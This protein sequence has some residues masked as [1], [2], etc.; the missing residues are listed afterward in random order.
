[1]GDFD[2]AKEELRAEI[3]EWLSLDEETQETLRVKDELEMKSDKFIHEKEYYMKKIYFS[4]DYDAVDKMDISVQFCET[5]EERDLWDYLKIMTMSVLTSEDGIGSMKILVKENTTGTYIGLLQLTYDIF[6]M[7]DRDQYIGWTTANKKATAGGH[8]MNKYLINIA[9]CIG[10]QPMA[11]N[12]N[13]GKLLVAIVFST[14]VL[15]YFKKKRGYYYTCVITTSLFGKSIQYDRLP[16]IKL[17]GY[18][19][20]YGVKQFPVSMTER[21]LAFYNKYLKECDKPYKKIHI[22]RRVFM[23]LGYGRETLNHGQKRGIYVGYISPKS[24]DFLMEK[25][26]EFGLENVKP[27][28]ERVTWWKERWA[29]NRYERLYVEGKL[30]IMYEM[31][32]FKSTDKKNQKARQYLYECY[33]GPDSE[34]YREKKKAYNKEY[35]EKTKLVTENQHEIN[36]SIKKRTFT[37][38]E[39]IEIALMKEKKDKKEKLPNGDKIT[40]TTA[41]LYLSSLFGKSLSSGNLRNYWAN[42]TKVYEFEFVDKKITYEQYMAI[43]SK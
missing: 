31:K 30:K 1:M 24:A 33:Y 43:M 27:L 7:H 32:Y 9:T 8:T 36:Q 4:K 35:Y 21:V 20:G 38:D 29:R 19:K 26:T 37:I 14:E 16:F 6:S 40:S 23:E 11:H 15:E 10:L 3:E 5:E 28:S 17:V 2:K 12:M 25:C 39:I 41:A 13:I 18:T 34:E 22:Y 42:L